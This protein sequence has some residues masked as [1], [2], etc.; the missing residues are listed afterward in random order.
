MPGSVA[1][2]TLCII[3]TQRHICGLLAMLQIWCSRWYKVSHIIANVLQSTVVGILHVKAHVQIG[4]ASAY[5]LT[6]TRTC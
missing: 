5:A 6:N 2:G 3:Y 4:Y 1:S